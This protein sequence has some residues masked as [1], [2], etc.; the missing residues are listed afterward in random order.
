MRKSNYHQIVGSTIKVIASADL[1]IEQDLRD[2]N[3]ENKTISELLDE[4]K[5]KE[6]E[7]YTTKDI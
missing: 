2:N 6:K 5:E 3:K 4:Q 1:D 7:Q